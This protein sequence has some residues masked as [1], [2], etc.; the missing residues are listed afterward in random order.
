MHTRD[1]VI[2]NYLLGYMNI[3]IAARFNLCPYNLGTYISKLGHKFPC[4]HPQGLQT[5]HEQK[6]PVE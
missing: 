1:I 6:F 3:V 2:Y 5:N 4:Q